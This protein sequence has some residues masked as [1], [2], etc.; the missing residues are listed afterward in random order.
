MK[1]IILS[2]PPGWGKTR[3]AEALRIELGCTSVVDEFNPYFDDPTPGALH[4]TSVWMDN[5]SRFKYEIAVQVV[6]RGWA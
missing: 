3:N 5:P 1:T 2:A 6:T 4:L